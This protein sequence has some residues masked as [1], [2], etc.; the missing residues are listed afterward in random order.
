MAAGAGLLDASRRLLWRLLTGCGG[1]G[2][3]GGGG[4]WDAAAATEEAMREPGAIFCV[5]AAVLGALSASYAVESCL[6]EEI[7]IVDLQQMRPNGRTPRWGRKCWPAA[8]CSARQ[9]QAGV[10][11]RRD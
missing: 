11:D 9:R 8:D 6:G 5:L 4:A 2:G 7:A 10:E 3:S 1:G